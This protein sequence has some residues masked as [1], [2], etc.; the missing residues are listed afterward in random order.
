MECP[1]CKIE[2]KKV[3]Y[4]LGFEVSVDSFSCPDCMLNL[5]DEKKLDKAIAELRL[6]KNNHLFWNNI[7]T[8]SLLFKT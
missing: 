7:S 5:T 8:T 3:E 1:R 2:M 6:R 4:D